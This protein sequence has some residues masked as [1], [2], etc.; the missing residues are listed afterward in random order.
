MATEHLIFL[1]IPGLRP[2]DI[3][4]T[5]TPTLFRWA[6]SGAACE[7][8]PTFPCLTSPVQATMWTGVAPGDHGVIANGFFHRDRGV[9]EFWVAHNDIIQGEQLWDVIRRR[10]PGFTSAV[11]HAQNIK[12]AGA[13]FIV[14]PAP[15]HEPDGT[16]KLWCYAKPDG[17]YQELLDAIGHFPL[18]HY[19]GPLA[20]IESTRWILRG[21][22]RLTQ[23]HAPNFHWI[24]LPHLDYASQKF[25]PD[26]DQ[27]IR[28][29]TE[30]DIELERFDAGVRAT[31][32][33]DD[34]LYL[35]AG[36]YAL[37]AVS[38]V[39]HPNRILR[40]AGLLSIR[41]EDDGEYIDPAGSRAFAMVD[42]QLTHVYVNDPDTATRARVTDLFRSEP[43]VAAVYEGD[44][45]RDVGLAHRRAGE[46]VLV[47]D[48]QHWFANYWWLD[49]AAAPP[50][51]RTV[52][53]HRKP[54]YDPVELFVDPVTRSIPLD[55][56]LVK[57]S[58]GAPAGDAR[59][60]AALICSAPTASVRPDRTYRDTEIKGIVLDLL[61]LRADG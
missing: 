30:L 15:I 13:D 41:R 8:T 46:I 1:S 5:T 45:R 58:H 2:T 27:A 49:D 57:G 29:L 48:D 33:A 51:T 54:G 55:A 18:Q 40:D 24:Y 52:D 20:N 26:S 38:G 43:G 10:R 32:I 53:I 37:T 25:G 50:F 16:M 4:R 22:V 34:V 7:L 44:A 42:H 36:E 61:G 23:R 14:T 6:T 35:V 28:A 31:E 11:W 17:L 59:Q 9:V 3:D 21:A 60:K 47:A 19:W 56:S 39:I 12:G